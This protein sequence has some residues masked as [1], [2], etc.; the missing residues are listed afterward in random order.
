MSVMILKGKPVADHLLQ[1]LKKDIEKIKLY[2][3]LVVILVGSDS[4]SKYYA[5]N[6]Q[7]QGKK[8][9]ID[10]DILEFK[11]ISEEE[12]IIQIKLL[13][14]DPM[15]HGIMIQKPLP[16]YINEINVN[17]AIL[18]D[19][20]VDAIHPINAG[21]M[22]MEQESFHPCTAQAIIELLKYYG[23]KVKGKHTVI[24]GRSLVVGK[25]LANILLNKEEFCNATVTICH[26]QTENL[27]YYTK[28]ADVLICAIGKAN[29]ISSDMI[30]NGAILIDA[31]IN[32]IVNDNNEKQYVGD[33]DYGNCFHHCSA[34]TPVPGGVGSVTTAVLLK[35]VVMAGK[36]IKFLNKIVD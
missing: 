27:S 30:K 24:I 25:P 12:L 1:E 9:S 18:S 34:I 2:P 8:N 36:K 28:Q 11:Q 31:G 15:V 14:A 17:N 10:V 21:K 29:Y 19:K 22:F 4:A 6:I 5:S 33:V 7:K 16:K 35:H 26:S 32:E 13:N 3:K 23:I 20:D